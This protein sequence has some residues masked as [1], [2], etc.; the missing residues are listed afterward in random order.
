[1]EM[2]I[3]TS[4]YWIYDSDTIVFKPHFNEPIKIE[5]KYFKIISQYKNLIFSN[6]TNLEICIQNNNYSIALDTFEESKFNQPINELPSSLTEIYFG[7]CFNQPVNLP[8]SIIRL[9]F[10]G[11][12]NQLVDNLPD[13]IIH[14]EF[15]CYFNQPIKKLPRSLKFL[16][17]IDNFNKSI[18]LPEGLINLEFSNAF[19]Q[20]VELPNSLIH[21]YLNK[22]DNY[23][24]DNL[25]NSLEELKLGHLFRLELNNL[26][27]SLKIIRFHKACQ[28]KKELNNLPNSLELL[29][30]DSFYDKKIKNIS[31]NFKKII[32]EEKYKY[33]DD[34]SNFIIETYKIND[35]LDLSYV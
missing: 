14:L 22:G 33:I 5:S 10:G 17:F 9:H 3:E 2:E 21:L 12:F 26:P 31:K 1:M 35:Y 8:N 28:Y 6:Y 30:L 18:N 34:F 20:P 32:C 23:T 7:H 29:V 25:P 4:E 27:N 16:R 24:I 19:N 15:S 13:S 11:E